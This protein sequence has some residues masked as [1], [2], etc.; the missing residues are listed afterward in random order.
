[1][2]YVIQYPLSVGGAFFFHIKNYNNIL[3]YKMSSDWIN[4]VKQY[5]KN[6]NC[7]YKEALSKASATYKKGSGVGSS[8]KKKPNIQKKV[9]ESTDMSNSIGKFLT[10]AD[11]V[12]AMKLNKKGSFIFDVK[13]IDYQN[14]KVNKLLADYYN[15]GVEINQIIKREEEERKAIVDDDD[16]DD[17]KKYEKYN[18]LEA[19][20]IDKLSKLYAKRVIAGQ[21]LD[22][23]RA[24]LIDEMR[25]LNR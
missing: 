25:R 19:N 6:N 9:M 1:V 14:Q 20:T 16:I 2:C 17:D 10:P 15:I 3:I 18:K 22:E 23:A 13:K 7:S 21:R 5:A 8:S 24:E 11:R 12:K 4:H